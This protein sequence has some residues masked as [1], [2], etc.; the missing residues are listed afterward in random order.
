MFDETV[1]LNLNDTKYYARLDF[2]AIAL[3]QNELK[4]IKKNI[5]IPEM[6]EELTKEN[7]MVM[8]ELLVQSIKRCHT[9]LLSEDIYEN[10]KLKDRVEIT[11]GII[12]I[13]NS[14]MPTGDESDKKKAE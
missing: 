7:Y 9:Q 6:M 11:K 1:E 4:V 2:R 10:L 13:V 12:N 8:L 5:T 3:A 14:A